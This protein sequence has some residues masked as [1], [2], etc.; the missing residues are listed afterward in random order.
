MEPH[1]G[2]HILMEALSNRWPRRYVLGS[3]ACATTS[4]SVAA[5]DDGRLDLAAPIQHLAQH[6]LQIG[7]RGF[8]GH[9]VGAL[10]LVL[11]DQREGLT[12]YLGRVMES[13]FKCD[14][15]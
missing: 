14:L 15:G 13:G 12:N 5:R 9:I 4:A 8:A 6:F 11:R 2:L 1:P 3:S 10:N 7:E